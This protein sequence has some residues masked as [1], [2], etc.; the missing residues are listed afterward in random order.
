MQDITRGDFGNPQ[1]YEQVRAHN[2][3][4]DAIERS[5][6]FRQILTQAMGTDYPPESAQYSFIGMQGLCWIAERISMTSAGVCIDI[7]CGE[8][9][10]SNW[11]HRL[12]GR[13]ITGYDTSEKAIQIAMKKN[14]LNCN[15]VVADFCRLP[16]DDGSVAAI[17]ALDCVQH[18]PSPLLLANELARISIPGTRL[19]FTHWMRRFDPIMLARYD[20]LCSALSAAE[21]KI[22]EVTDLDPNLNIQFRVY[23]YV[24]ANRKLLEEELGSMLLDSLMSEA[25]HLHPRRSKV[26]HLAVSAVWDPN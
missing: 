16:I 26:G 12:C 15:F 2:N 13:K 21:F 20:P 3:V 22:E 4:Y 17:S 14:H 1:I 11:L 24:H 18:A 10:L 7:G 23:A 8:G 19:I 25:H 9:S 5:T 6:Y